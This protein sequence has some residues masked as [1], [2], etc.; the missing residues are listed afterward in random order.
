MT[1]SLLTFSPCFLVLLLLS[2]GLCW[3]P[4]SPHWILF[5]KTPYE[6]MAALQILRLSNDV[7]GEFKGKYLV[8]SGPHFNL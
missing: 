5:Y 3:V 8:L 2:I 4:E 6:C 7:G 1:Q